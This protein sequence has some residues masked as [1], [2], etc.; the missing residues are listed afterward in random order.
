MLLHISDVHAQAGEPTDKLVKGILAAI[1]PYTRPSYL[2]VSG[3]LGNRGQH[4]ALGV[5]L[6][7]MIAAGLDIPPTNIISCPGNHD[8]GHQ[9][10]RAPTFQDYHRE[11]STL[12]RDADRAAPTAAN[13]YTSGDYDFLT[14]NSAHRLDWRSGHVDIDALLKV[15]HR[16]PDSLGIVVVHHHLIPYDEGDTSEIANAYPV[17]RYLVENGYTLLLH[18]HRHVSVRLRIDSLEVVGAGTLNLKPQSNIN[19]QFNLISPGR[20]LY[21]FRFTGD[22][23]NRDGS[24]GAWVPTEYPQRP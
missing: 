2:I 18:G 23:D 19:N 22:V 10:N 24:I 21:R 3:D 17:V 11:V 1:E 15:R 8:I 6:V 4:I 7:R 9:P 14:L 12:L 13:M 16:R 5:R 20:V